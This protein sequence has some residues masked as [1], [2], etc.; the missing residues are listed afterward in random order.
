MSN[1]I[2]FLSLYIYPHTNALQQWSGG[3][4]KVFTH[5]C[6]YSFQKQFLQLGGASQHI[7]LSL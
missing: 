5:Q 3:R 4:D 2:Q 6:R 7:L 1:I